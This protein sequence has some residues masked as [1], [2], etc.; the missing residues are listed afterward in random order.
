LLTFV[1]YLDGHAIESQEKPADLR[2]TTK[3]KFSK[4]KRKK[5]ARDAYNTHHTYPHFAHHGQE[6]RG[7]QE[8]R[9]REQWRKLKHI[10]INKIHQPLL[11]NKTL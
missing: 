6:S 10:I 2:T 11:K 8:A 1:G 5:E 7:A 9:K 3:Q 4:E